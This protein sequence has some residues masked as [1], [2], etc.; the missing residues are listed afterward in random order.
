MIEERADKP[1]A[2]SSALVQHLCNG[3]RGNGDGRQVA[4]DDAQPDRF[5]GR[6]I[7]Q[8]R[9]ARASTRRTA[10][11]LRCDAHEDGH[12]FVARTRRARRTRHRGCGR[13]S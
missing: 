4:G 13:R 11:L 2:G 6:A 10:W 1:F 7:L 3:G 9:S 8:N 12:V 5:G